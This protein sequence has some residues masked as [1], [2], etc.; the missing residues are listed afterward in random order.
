MSRSISNIVALALFFT[1]TFATAEKVVEVSLI[2]MNGSGTPSVLLMTNLS[3]ELWQQTS[4]PSELVGE[5]GKQ[6]VSIQDEYV[7]MSAKLEPVDDSTHAV[8]FI[9]NQFKGRVVFGRE[10]T[11]VPLRDQSKLVYMLCGKEVSL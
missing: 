8:S 5:I 1:S 3:H 11:C 9:Y 4:G 2:P 6:A 7:N 10:E